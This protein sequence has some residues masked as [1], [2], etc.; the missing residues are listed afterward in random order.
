M[1]GGGAGDLVLPPSTATVQ[2]QMQ[3]MAAQQQRRQ[4]A[5]MQGAAQ[6]GGFPGA[7]ST[8]DAGAAPATP[9]RSAS[10]QLEEPLTPEDV[11]IRC[12]SCRNRK[13][14]EIFF[15]AVVSSYFLV[16]FG[17]PDGVGRRGQ[18]L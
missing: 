6:D 7:A 15:L 16:T 4:L 14:C 9:V 2:A 5:Q 17:I 12:I 11:R 10:G 18:V 13:T 8:H 1:P 3:A